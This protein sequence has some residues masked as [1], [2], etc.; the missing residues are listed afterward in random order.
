M[1]EASAWE[2]PTL[3][4]RWPGWAAPALLA[5]VAFGLRLGPLLVHRHLTFDD[6][7]YG[8]STIDMRHALL[9]YRDLFSSQG[10]LHYPL[11]YAGDLLTFRPLN[12]P[13]VVPVLAGVVATLGVW[14]V[15]RRLGS[16]PR[17]AVMAGI[18]VASS[19]SLLWATGPVSGDGPAVAFAVCA[20]WA[21]ARYRD[22]PASWCPP[23][24][25]ALFGAGLA[26]KAI[27]FPFAVPIGWLLWGRRRV[28][29]LAA[30]AAIA[31][32][33]AAALPWGLT[34]VW[35]QSIAFHFDKQANGSSLEQLGEVAG[36]LAQRDI[37]L[38]GAL[39]L[40]AVAG[41]V[42][43]R[44]RPTR[45][46]DLDVIVIS[47]WAVLTVLVLVFERLLLQLH[48][49]VLVPPLALLFAL[50][51]PPLRWLAISLVALVPLQ[52]LEISSVV[53]PKPYHGADA[54][55]VS[56]LRALPRAALVISDLQGFVWQS[57][58]STPRMLNDNSTSRIDQ[59]LVTTSKVAA[60]AALPATC[61]V[62]IWSYRFDTRLPGLRT[63]L[64]REG[65]SA[66]IFARG[67]ELWTKRRCRADGL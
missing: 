44:W 14:A 38:C 59:H 62:V 23:L 45:A 11:L 8:V 54:K 26:V 46:S 27:V 57:G 31:V 13:R 9:P 47:A 28:G 37:L 40:A 65:Y 60:G 51:P 25:G 66:R 55:L 1:R 32:W 2:A 22:R 35:S 53:W 64:S 10:P 15:A 49:A 67:K 3:I 33:F 56:S 6:G 61:A 30:A 52:A 4:G 36:W 41:I 39:L 7:C 63:A 24:A 17:S 19:G 43:P 58:H 21:A 5:V 34:R 42:L 48:L 18:L 20:V 29:S 12:G 16:P 50:R